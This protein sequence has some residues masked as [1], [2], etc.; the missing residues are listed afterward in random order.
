MT[1]LNERRAFGAVLCLCGVLG[2]SSETPVDPL[3]MG[4]S[5][6]TAGAG[7][8]PGGVT[9]VPDASGWIGRGAE[10]NGI[11]VQGAWY[12]YGDKYGE[13]KCTMVGLHAPEECSTI[14]SPDPLVPGFPNTD[15]E[16]CTSGETAVVLGCKEGVP[17]CTLGS[18][19]YSN[20]WGAGIGLDLNAEGAPS[21]EPAPKAPWNPDEQG[22]VGIAFDI[23]VVPPPGLRVEF[24]IVLPDGS[25]TENHVDG[26]P[27]WGAKSNYPNSDVKPGRNQFRWAEVAVP[28]MNYAF[29]RTQILSIQFHVPAVTTGANR[30]AYSFCVKNLTFLTN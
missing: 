10:G 26:S 16:M 18:P 1:N 14:T 24:P 23:D 29:D 22:V 21:G 25:T 6:G 12:P 27:Y 17:R 8:G 11:A 13:A 2:C 28:T 30:G 7:A 5:A 19:D 15:G 20:M 4:G 9:L 3:A